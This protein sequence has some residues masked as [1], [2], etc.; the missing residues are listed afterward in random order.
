MTSCAG[1]RYIVY[2]CT[3]FPMSDF[4]EFIS[5][6]EL[7]DLTTTIYNIVRPQLNSHRFSTAHDVILCSLI[8]KMAAQKSVFKW[9]NSRYGHF[10]NLILLYSGYLSQIRWY[11]RKLFLLLMTFKTYEDEFSSRISS[12]SIVLLS[13]PTI[14]YP[15]HKLLETSENN[16]HLDLTNNSSCTTRQIR[17]FSHNAH[18]DVHHYLIDSWKLHT[19]VIFTDILAHSPLGAFQWPIT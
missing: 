1:E 19:I 10:Y 2:S 4:H 16:D 6:S 11:K 13:T 9:Y 14:E 15:G 12:R 5:F 3:T 17:K 18:F 7:S 8:L